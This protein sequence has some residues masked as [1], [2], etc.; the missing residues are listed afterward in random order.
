MDPLSLTGSFSTG[1][2][3]ILPPDQRERKIRVDEDEDLP[4]EESEDSWV[5]V[6]EES[7]GF[8][9]S[10]EPST[11]TLAGKVISFGGKVLTTAY[12][13]TV[14]QLHK[15]SSKPE[16]IGWKIKRYE[17]ILSNIFSRIRNY[18]ETEKLGSVPDLLK[19][20]QSEDGLLWQKQ[21]QPILL[22]SR[23]DLRDDSDRL[24]LDY[25]N[26]LRKS[27]TGFLTALRNAAIWVTE[28]PKILGGEHIDAFCY[29]LYSSLNINDRCQDIFDTFIALGKKECLSSKKKHKALFSL[30]E[31]TYNLIRDVEESA[32]YIQ[33]APRGAK[34]PLLSGALNS[35]TGHVGGTG[36]RSFD[37]NM[38][39][40][41]IH[42]FFRTVMKIGDN[43]PVYI[44]NIACGSPT[45]EIGIKR[46]MIVPE[47]RGFLRYLKE[48]LKASH[49]YINNQDAIPR[50]RIEGDESSRCQALHKLARDEFP[51]N[52]TVITFSQNSKFFDQVGHVFSGLNVEKIKNTISH[53]LLSHDISIPMS[54]YLPGRFMTS[55]AVR[56]WIV[57][58]LNRLH[59]EDYKN[60]RDFVDERERDYFVQTFHNS[61]RTHL[62]ELLKK[63]RL[64]LGEKGWGYSI[65][66]P[67]ISR[68]KKEI[69][70]Q[71]FDLP[72]E[73]T[74]N[75]ISPSLVEEFDLRSWCT[76]AVDLIHNLVFKSRNRMDEEHRKIFILMVYLILGQKIKVDLIKSRNLKTENITCKDGIDRGAMFRAMLYAYLAILNDMMN[77]VEV[78]KS[79]KPLFFSRALIVR[80]RGVIDRRLIRMINTVKFMLENPEGIRE[81]HKRLFPNILMTIDL[82]EE[83]SREK[84]S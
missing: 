36:F 59:V 63:N 33:E 78:I 53:E 67:N 22:A 77:N 31:P 27:Y 76:Q 15:E 61:L 25:L 34:V 48:K 37:P 28:N 29:L 43:D 64:T 74:G 69:I 56:E 82:F 24:T 42:V 5:V 84:Q 14:G 62:R 50:S 71:L 46:V 55:E 66:N 72:L 26:A 32:H 49:L 45:C 1:Y 12:S 41:V 8:I 13:G 75:Y 54:R 51:E 2:S 40:N 57:K 60:C 18:L 68:F 23:K 38:Q 20:S 52:L 4:E 83:F 6:N 79:S 80:K 7:S 17:D 47:F 19:T 30:E 44:D 39:S 11:K 73:Q 3:S 81:L 35:F 65:Y 16:H 70:A 10:D 9:G 58:E 21:V